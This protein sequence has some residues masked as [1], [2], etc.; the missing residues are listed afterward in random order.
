MLAVGVDRADRLA[1]QP[2]GPAVA[3]EARVQR[4]ERVRARGLRGRPDAVRG[5]VDRVALGHAVSVGAA[6]RS[7][8]LCLKALGWRRTGVSHAVWRHGSSGTPSLAAGRP[9]SVN[10]RWSELPVP[11]SLIQRTAPR[12][13]RRIRP[14]TRGRFGGGAE[15]ERGAAPDLVEAR[16]RSAGRLRAALHARDGGAG[17]EVVGLPGVRPLLGAGGDQPDVAGGADRG[18]A[19]RERDE[20]PDPGRVVVRPGRGRHR[21]RVRGE[22][23]EAVGWRVVDADDVARAPVAGHAEA[24]VRDA[25]AGGPEALLHPRVRA[26][27]GGGARGARAGARE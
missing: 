8:G 27:L 23:D 3:A 18:E 17:A 6:R 10:S 12:P 22:H 20:R 5:V 9:A 2:L 26:A 11:A 1:F 25:E 19:G 15:V 13:A 21:V 24:V 14:S 16:A 4:L 7:R